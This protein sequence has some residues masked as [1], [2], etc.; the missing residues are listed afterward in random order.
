MKAGTAKKPC[1]I[2]VHDIKLPHNI[3]NGLLAFHAITG[4]D[5]TSQFT[6][7]GKR[8]A[9]KVFQQY[10]HLLQNFGEEEMP[11]PD[12]LRMAE[13]FV[14]K[15]YDPKSSS[16]SIHEVRCALFRKVKANVDTLPPTKDALSLHLMRAHYQTKIW[17]QSL[18][19]HPQL[20]SPTSCGWHMTDGVLV[21]KLLTKEPLQARSLELTTCGCKE[22]GTQ[23]ST[24]QCRCRRGGMFCCG[25]CGCGSAAWCKN[26]QVTT[27]RY[28][29]YHI[30]FKI[31]IF[32][33]M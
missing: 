9:W 12:T 32:L 7:I 1:F 31:I 24:R 22:S 11:S 10:P 27:S 20:P 8:T 15:L 28:H 21:P 13:Q 14:C 29:M 5:T 4:C 6:G 17:K 23:C 2:K 16:E 19:S 30:M 33:F 3:S 18:V 26:T 25:A